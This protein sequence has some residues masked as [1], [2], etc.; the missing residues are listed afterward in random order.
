MHYVDSKIYKHNF[1]YK[2]TKTYSRVADVIVI[3]EYALNSNTEFIS[4]VYKRRIYFIHHMSIKTID[5]LYKK[6]SKGQNNKSQM[7]FYYIP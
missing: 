7:L 2:K 5:P 1:E 4:F 6:I 3:G